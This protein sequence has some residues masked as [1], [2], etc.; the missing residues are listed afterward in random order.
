MSNDRPS[1]R[2]RWNWVLAPYRKFRSV[3]LSAT[4]VTTR[5]TREGWQFAFMISFV[6]LGAVVR[7]VNLLVI[8]AGTMLAFL[9]IQWRICARSIYGV[10]LRRKLP[11]HIQARKPF[12]VEVFLTNPKKY[13]GAW[14]VVV[15]DRIVEPTPSGKPARDANVLGLM[16]PSLPAQETRVLR[17][18][19]S[20][21]RRGVYRFL[22]AQVTSRFPLGLMRGIL[23]PADT[24]SIVVQPSVGQ[25]TSGWNELLETKRSGVKQRTTRALSDE[26]DFFG[27][28]AYHYGDSIRSVHWRSSARTN[29]L[30]VKQF[31]RSDS[32]EIVVVLDLPPRGTSDK[33]LNQ[34]NGSWKH[35]DLA[36]EFV[37]TLAHHISA[38]NHGVL[39][40]A[41]ADADPTL[42]FRIQTRTQTQSLLDRLGTATPGKQDH[43]EKALMLLEH[44]Y[45]FVERLIVVSTRPEPIRPDS[46][47]EVESTSKL[48]IFWHNRIWLDASSNQLDYYFLAT[49]Q[50]A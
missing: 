44:Q 8:L 16:L 24:N 39:S 40:V 50:T 41:I 11:H 32:R 14:W 23:P 47:D 35:E 1:I 26:G 36:C 27:I 4:P 7:N 2:S 28:R 3:R 45:R 42:A 6:V 43:L 48:P 15:E 10:T 21:P 12:S 37:A 18:E 30:M 34:N 5:L 25:L 49:P 9:L 29:E 17:Y 33:A 46:S 13:L 20:M 22:G 19:C 38:S 31:Q